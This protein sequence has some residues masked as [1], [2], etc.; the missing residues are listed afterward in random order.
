MKFLK[1]CPY[2]GKKISVDLSVKNI[3]YRNK[4]QCPSCGEK[5]TVGMKAKYFILFY[6]FAILL[7]F[8]VYYPLG[9]YS[10]SYGFLIVA[11][12]LVLISPYSYL[13]FSHL[14]KSQL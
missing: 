8:I 1:E 3:F 2:C 12:I 4:V 9:F 6:T 5:S 14:K 7:S 11:L 10:S 13:F